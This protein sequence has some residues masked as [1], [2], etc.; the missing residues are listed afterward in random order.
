MPKKEKPT[1]K[2]SNTW[3]LNNTQLS[4]QWIIKEKED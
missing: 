2:Y 3:K 4:N 1:E